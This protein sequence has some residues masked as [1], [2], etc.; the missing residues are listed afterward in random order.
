MSYIE[1][2]SSNIPNFSKAVISVWF[3]APQ[4]SIESAAASNGIIPIVTFGQIFSAF[5][6]RN[7]VSSYSYSYTENVYSTAFTCDLLLQYT[8]TKTVTYP[9]TSR[10]ADYNLDQCYI[11]LDCQSGFPSTA[12]L[13]VCLQTQDQAVKSGIAWEPISGSSGTVNAYEG[14]PTVI[15]GCTDLAEIDGAFVIAGAVTN[16]VTDYGDITSLVNNQ[17]ESFAATSQTI[18]VSPDKWHHVLL[19]FDLS[20]SVVATGNLNGAGQSLSS[21]C[22]LWLAFDDVNYTGDDLPRVPTPFGAT[23]GPN[24]IITTPAWSAFLTS[25]TTPTEQTG[26]REAGHTAATFYQFDDTFTGQDTPPSYNLSGASISIAGQ[27]MGLPSVLE[28]VSNIHHVELAEFQMFTGVTLDTSVVNNRRAFIGTDGK[29]VDPTKALPGAAPGS[30]PPG[31]TATGKKPDVLF[32]GSR[33]WIKGK[34][35]GALG[36]NPDGSIN[37]S[38]Q[39]SPSGKIKKYIPD[40]GLPPAPQGTPQ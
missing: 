33:N 4:S 20:G 9:L 31:V 36:I 10:D 7:D 14:V 19:S 13:R 12:N 2:S 32:H 38:G 18:A 15:G 30:P 5:R 3:R 22:K 21:T 25:T 39:F 1:Q 27:P 17:N 24:D 11:G 8:S 29:P 26:V 23:L 35:T 37:L 28:T 34:N 40:P 6:T 16:V